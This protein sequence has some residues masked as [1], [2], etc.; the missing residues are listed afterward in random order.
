MG[1]GSFTTQDIARWRLIAR[2]EA[3]IYNWWTLLVRLAQPYKHLEAISSHPLLLHGVATQRR[4]G[5]RTRLTITSTHAKQAKIHAVLV[6]LAAFLNQLK[7]IA[8]QLTMLN[9]CGRHSIVH[10]P[11]SSFQ[12]RIGRHF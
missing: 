4:H 10:S 8:K 11:N 1:M 5:G 3:L 7:S 2:T 6:N 12:T 9:A